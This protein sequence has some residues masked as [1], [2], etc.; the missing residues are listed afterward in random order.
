MIQSF[1]QK[2]FFVVLVLGL[3]CVRAHA[4]S[5]APTNPWFV[6]TSVLGVM[7]TDSSFKVDGHF[8][9][10]RV[11]R[12]YRDQYAWEVEYLQDDLDFGVDYNLRHRSLGVNHRTINHAVLWNPYILIG[13]A[14]DQF[15]APN[16]TQPNAEKSGTDFALNVGLGGEWELMAP[17]KL[18]LRLD[19]RLRYD[20]NNTR[21]PGQ[22]G[23]GD[24]VIGLGLTM[25]FAK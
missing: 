6:G 21:Q 16:A 13:V 3:S 18:M 24:G 23:F 1:V 4:Q 20:F 7:V 9:A 15:D 12:E 17:R 10:L 22:I 19:L 8:A 14:V 2:F 5:P 11:G 25:P